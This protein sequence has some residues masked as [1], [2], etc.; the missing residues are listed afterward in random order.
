MAI[1]H[2]SSNIL[3]E[4]KNINSAVLFHHILYWVEYNKR[5]KH[6]HYDNKYWFYHS[7]NQFKKR[8]DYLTI[9]QIEYS[10]KKLQE[11]N[12]III[13][14]KYSNTN[15]VGIFKTTLWYTISDHGYE[16]LDEDIEYATEQIE[17]RWEKKKKADKFW[18]NSG[19]SFSFSNS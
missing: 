9:R 1:Y 15:E 4:C 11:R 7:Y 5:V 16:I 10:L 2:F 19:N 14:D 13:T 6:L 3:A 18:N 17:G 8:F 12:L